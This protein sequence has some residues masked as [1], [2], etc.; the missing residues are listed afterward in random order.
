[1]ILNRFTL[2]GKQ[3]V[4]VNAAQYALQHPLPVIGTTAS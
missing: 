1:V 4:I 2:V 3:M